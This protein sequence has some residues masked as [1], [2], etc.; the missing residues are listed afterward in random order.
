[1]TAVAVNLLESILRLCAEAAPRPWYPRRYAEQRGADAA[2]LAACLEQLHQADLVAE[3]PGTPES[4]PG[5]I[6]TPAGRRALDDPEMLTRLGQGEPI[7]AESRRDVVLRALRQPL[8]PWLTR[9][10]VLVNLLVFAYEVFLV[11]KLGHPIGAFLGVMMQAPAWVVNVIEHCGGVTATDVI[12]GHWWRL[13]TASFV[14]VGLLFL[15]L[16]LFMMWSAGRRVERMWGRLGLLLLYLAG[17]V[18]SSVLSLARVGRGEFGASG[19]VYALFAAE[20]AWLLLNRRYLPEDVRRQARR[21][22]FGSVLILTLLVWLSGRAAWWGPLGGAVA[23]GSVALL[24]HFHRFTPA[25]WRW[26]SLAGFVLLSW[27]GYLV[28][29]RARATE[30]EWHEAEREVF[31]RRYLNPA[32]TTLKRSRRVYEEQIKPLTEIHPIRRDPAAVEAALPVLAEQRRKLDALAGEL[33]AIGPYHSETAEEARKA[34]LEYTRGQARLFSM[35]EHYLQVGEKR[36]EADRRE[37]QAQA[38]AVEKQR[39]V[40]NDLIE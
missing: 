38:E 13:V 16:D 3:V 19:P 29:E 2:D 21:G 9:L 35:A 34:A 22:L 24:L 4:G 8:T 36:T 25:P 17:A 10:L 11:R 7:A 37:L 39:R 15:A 18:G 12:E 14:H 32:N 6:L 27:A 23:G 30:K 26:L 40:W 5:L 28:L 20:A 31:Q 33:E 1:M